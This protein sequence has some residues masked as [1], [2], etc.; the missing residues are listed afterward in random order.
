M[1]LESSNPYNLPLD[2]VLSMEDGSATPLPAQS[3]DAPDTVESLVTRLTA[4]R[5]RL[6]WLAA[7]WATT[8]SPDIA[9]EADRYREL[10]HDLAEQLRKQDPDKVDGLIVG[11]EALLLCEPS[12]K[13]TLPMAAQQWFELAGEVRSQHHQPLRPKSPGYVP[14]GL[15]SFV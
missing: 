5:E 3:E 1:P 14:D 7:C 10:F 12:P 11:H 6:F 13:P 2:V 9:R 4:I 8:L 15:S